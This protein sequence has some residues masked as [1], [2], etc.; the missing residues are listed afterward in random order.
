MKVHNVMSTNIVTASPDESICELWKHII[1]RRINAVPVIDRRRRLIGLVTKEDLLKALYPDYR[2]YLED[3]TSAHDFE[4]MEAN[5]GDVVKLKANDIMCKKVIYT[6]G[7][8]PL[9]R[10]LSRMIVRRV[11][12]LPVIDDEHRVIGMITKSDVFSAL[13]RWH[14]RKAK[15]SER[16]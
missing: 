4:Q 15:K 6:L 16:T 8:T 9:M 1:K 7:D 5:V 2:E 11:N 10:A 12:Q 13:F 14:L 3:V